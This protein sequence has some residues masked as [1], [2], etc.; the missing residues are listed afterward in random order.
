MCAKGRVCGMI[1]VIWYRGIAEM[2]RGRSGAGEGGVRLSFHGDL[3]EI[4]VLW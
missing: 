1:G 3:G 4:M 2:E